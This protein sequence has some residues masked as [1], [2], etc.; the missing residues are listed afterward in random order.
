MNKEVLEKI[1]EEAYSDEMEK[2]SGI[3]TNV[4]NYG[5]RVLNTP[6][7]I[8]K[9]TKRIVRNSKIIKARKMERADP[10]VAR[11]FDYNKSIG[12]AKGRVARS[13]LSLGEDLTGVVAPIVVGGAALKSGHSEYKRYK[14]NK[15][16]KKDILNQKQGVI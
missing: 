1:A 8:Y 12:D 7:N 16:L 10:G 6:R 9:Q 2:I 13:I 14:K 5:K 11:H 3:K 4:L 15:R